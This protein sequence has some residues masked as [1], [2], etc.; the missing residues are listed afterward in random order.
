MHRTFDGKKV[1]HYIGP[2]PIPWIMWAMFRTERSKTI[3]T[4]DWAP[5]PAHFYVDSAEGN[6]VDFDVDTINARADAAEERLGGIT[7]DASNK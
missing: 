4:G 3:E 6:A 2:F 7:N 1:R 5:N